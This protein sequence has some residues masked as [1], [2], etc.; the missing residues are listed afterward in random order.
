MIVFALVVA[1]IGLWKRQGKRY[2]L[3]LLMGVGIQMLASFLFAGGGTIENPAGDG[4]ITALVRQ[5][6]GEAGAVSTAFLVVPLAW[7][8]PI[9][10]VRRAYESPES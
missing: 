6:F 2:W 7:L 10:L 5:R 4:L 8:I 1:A 3:A 9:D